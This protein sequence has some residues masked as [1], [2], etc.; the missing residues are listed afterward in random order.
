MLYT[1]QATIWPVV[2]NIINIHIFSKFVKSLNVLLNWVVSS[3]KNFELKCLCDWD[4]AAELI[5]IPIQLYASLMYK[6]FAFLSGSF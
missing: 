4:T 3:W 2:I 1:M 5:T 6:I